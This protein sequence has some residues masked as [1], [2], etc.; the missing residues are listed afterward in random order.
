MGVVFKYFFDENYIFII[1]IKIRKRY[2]VS[3]GLNSN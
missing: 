2:T 3:D 1:E